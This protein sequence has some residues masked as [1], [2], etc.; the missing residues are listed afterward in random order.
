MGHTT[1]NKKKAGKSNK[2]TTNRKNNF[3]FFQKALNITKVIK[4]DPTVTDDK[5]F[6]LKAVRCW[7]VQFQKCSERLKRDID[8]IQ[9]AVAKD[10][11][12]IF[13]TFIASDD[14][15]LEKDYPQIYELFFESTNDPDLV[16]KL[17]KV[18]GGEDCVNEKAVEKYPD[19][20][21]IVSTAVQWNGMLL[22]YASDRL[23]SNR[24][25]VYTAL[26]SRCASFQHV[27]KQLQNDRSIVLYAIKQKVDGFT[28]VLE[29][30]SK[31]LQN[32]REVV[33]AALTQH[34]SAL[35][36]A[37]EEL[38]NDRNVVLAAVTQS[39][40][41]LKYASEDLK[42]DREVVLAAVTQD[43]N[44]LAYAS[45]EFQNDRA[46]VLAALTE[47][48]WAFQYASKELRDDPEIQQ[49]VPNWMRK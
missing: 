2:Q 17:Q 20:Y 41:A 21:N 44:A 18:T 10:A 26:K 3:D 13:S 49:N 42:R 9:A 37:S 32:D 6:M 19:N 1:A 4:L 33:L 28:S 14:K 16:E 8:I 46:V 22:K 31:K 30:A 35:Q 27:P 24:K 47:N 38:Q 48:Q 40:W 43:G 23:K 15:L 5:E 25:I 11:R 45:E 34:S 29:Y 39:G 7:G 36:Y 12:N